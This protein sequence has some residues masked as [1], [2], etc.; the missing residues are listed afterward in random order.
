M[1]KFNMT[2]YMRKWREKNRE[3]WNE[4]ARNRIKANKEKKEEQEEELKIIS[5]KRNFF[6]K[7]GHKVYIHKK[8]KKYYYEIFF[9]DFREH[10]ISQ[11]FSSRV[12]LNKDLMYA[13]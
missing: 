3:R 1:S 4:L 6:I 10:Y 11:E 8:G 12:N 2:E 13:I 7:D 5:Q 9:K